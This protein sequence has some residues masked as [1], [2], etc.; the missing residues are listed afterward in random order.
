MANQV[1][2]KKQAEVK[3]QALKEKNKEADGMIWASLLGS[4]E[5]ANLVE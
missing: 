1:Q 5:M 3:C 2:N 4:M